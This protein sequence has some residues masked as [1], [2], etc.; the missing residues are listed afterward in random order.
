VIRTAVLAAFAVSALATS[1]FAFGTQSVPAPRVG[2]DFTDASMLRGMMPATASEPFHFGPAE[3]QALA[4]DLPQ[5]NKATVIY[6]LKGGKPADHI[7]VTDPRDNPFLP[8]PERRAA[9]STEA[10]H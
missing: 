4:P 1:A 5:S 9:R 10:S 2:A 7:D 6:E 3:P 8:Q